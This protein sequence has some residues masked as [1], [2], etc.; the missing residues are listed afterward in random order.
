MCLLRDEEVTTFEAA[1]EK[2]D[3]VSRKTLFYLQA[4]PGDD[5][6]KHTSP[7]S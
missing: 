2:D 1:L 5:G 6:R 4:H 3:T 7:P